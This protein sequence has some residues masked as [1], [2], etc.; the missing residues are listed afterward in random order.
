M[1]AESTMHRVFC[2][3]LRSLRAAGKLTQEAMAERLGM[4][5]PQYAKI[6]NGSNV[7][8]LLTVE[9]ITVALGVS[10]AELLGSLRPQKQLSA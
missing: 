10:V 3:N 4:T 8:S 7:P 6:E 1:P 2:Q 5:Q 9:R